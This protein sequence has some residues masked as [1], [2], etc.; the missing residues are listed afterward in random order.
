MAMVAEVAHHT[1]GRLRLRIS[2]RRKD[3]PFFL[4]LYEELRRIPTLGEVTMNPL[5]GSVLLQFD[6]ANR[7]AVIEALST[8]RLIAV[9]QTPLAASAPRVPVDTGDAMEA[10]LARRT[11]DVR[12]LVFLII[13]ALSVHQLLK[14]QLLAPI[15]TLVLYGLDLAT[16]YRMEKQDP[17]AAI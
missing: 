17:D 16:T 2:E 15:L 7:S 12:T 11:T 6:E 1:R 9:S 10:L 8:S 4:A 13:A 14:G 5:T 3:L